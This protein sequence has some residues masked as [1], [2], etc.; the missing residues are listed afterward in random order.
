M[1]T[2]Y[3]CCALYLYRKG[4]IITKNDSRLQIDSNGF[5]T[6][7]DF[8]SINVPTNDDFLLLF[9]SITKDEIKKIIMQL[10]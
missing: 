1:F 2:I 3:H 7:W 4:I 5:I 10:R 8:D 6:Q 9:K